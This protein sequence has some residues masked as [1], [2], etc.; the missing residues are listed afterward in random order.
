M[1][2]EPIRSQAVSFGLSIA[3]NLVPIV[4]NDAFNATA[5]ATQQQAWHS[6]YKAK[7]DS[8]KRIQNF[9]GAI[10]NSLL[11]FRAACYENK[12]I[13]DHIGGLILEQMSFFQIV[14]ELLRTR[15]L[16]FTINDKLDIKNAMGKQFEL[17]PISNTKATLQLEIFLGEKAKHLNF[18]ANN[19]QVYRS[20]EINEFLRLNFSNSSYGISNFYHQQKHRNGFSTESE[21]ITAIKNGIVNLDDD[22]TWKTQKNVFAFTAVKDVDNNSDSDD[23][24]ISGPA[25]NAM[26]IDNKKKKKK[27]KTIKVSAITSN[28]PSDHPE[29]YC[30]YEGHFD[31]GKPATHSNQACHERIKIKLRQA[32]FD[33][34]KVVDA[35]AEAAIKIKASKIALD[36]PLPR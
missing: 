10:H 19:G 12:F 28:L 9:N 7:M 33:K 31:N 2:L 29:T 27:K 14:H 18:A 5:T 6:N 20:E 32:H 24:T 35:A 25:A 1:G 4:F 22:L 34:H 23:S 11:Q 3:P 26:K 21:I 15:V 13:A 17:D 36:F 8:E 16:N 30:N